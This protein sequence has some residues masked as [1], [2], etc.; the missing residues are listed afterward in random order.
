MD[1][2]KEIIKK[3]LKFTFQAGLVPQDASKEEFAQAS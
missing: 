2:F 3:L 1:L